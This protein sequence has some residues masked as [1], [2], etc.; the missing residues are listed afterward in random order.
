MITAEHHAKNERFDAGGL[1]GAVII[2]ILIISITAR[3]QGL[4]SIVC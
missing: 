3:G 4:Q 1:R 2:P